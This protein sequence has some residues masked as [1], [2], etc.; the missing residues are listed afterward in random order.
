MEVPTI[1]EHIQKIYADY[2]L[3]EG[4]T[5][6]NF[7]IVQTEGSRQVSREGKHYSLRNSNPVSTS[8]LSQILPSPPAAPC[9][10]AAFLS[11]LLKR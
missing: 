5:I 7:R 11:P 10:G 9:E 2:E 3:E 8:I 4:A 1:N 6:R